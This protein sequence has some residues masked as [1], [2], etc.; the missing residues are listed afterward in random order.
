M[1]G[2]CYLEG[3]VVD[4][5]TSKA[6]EFWEVAAKKGSYYAH[7]LLASLDDMNGNTNGCVEHLK[8]AASAGH[9][10]SMNYL[11]DTYKRKLVSKEDLAKTLRAYQAS[12]DEM[13]SEDREDAR[14]FGESRS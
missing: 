6:V 8:V 9:N 4:Q 7:S 13:K 12:T 2:Q 1:I 11:M 14:A 10:S 5:N 3:T